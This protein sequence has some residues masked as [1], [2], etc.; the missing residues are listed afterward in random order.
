[1]ALAPPS[2]R[3]RRCNHLPP[4]VPAVAAAH[5]NVTAV[6]RCSRRKSRPT[7]ASVCL[8]QQQNF[9]VRRRHCI[10]DTLPAR[11]TQRGA[12][13]RHAV[14][15]APHLCWCRARCHRACERRTP[16][17]DTQPSVRSERAYI[18]YAGR[19]GPQGQTEAGIRSGA[20]LATGRAIGGRTAWYRWVGGLH[21][22]N[23]YA[24]QGLSKV[25]PSRPKDDGRPP[26]MGHPRR[27]CVGRRC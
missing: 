15:P 2:H 16:H 18:G 9:R 14:S 13:G 5:R 23:R 21:P 1:M 20:A 24:A 26:D 6:T 7:A 3:Q 17:S 4:A 19:G 22:L 25:Q 27:C 10:R 8:P 11:A 12:T